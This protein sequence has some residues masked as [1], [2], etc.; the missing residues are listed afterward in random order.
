VSLSSLLL[1]APGGINAR[2]TGDVAETAAIA[3]H[4]ATRTPEVALVIATRC[5][6]HPR[7]RRAATFT[8][9][10]ASHTNTKI[11]QLKTCPV[12][13]VYLL[14]KVKQSYLLSTIRWL[15]GVV[16]GDGMIREFDFELLAT[17]L[18]TLIYITRQRHEHH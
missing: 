13:S 18:Y 7:L 12:Y 15:F 17:A 10:L 6:L 16:S 2:V 14:T 1:L 4:T 8:H 3:V 11:R 9:P 5:F